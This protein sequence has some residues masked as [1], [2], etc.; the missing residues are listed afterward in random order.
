MFN[1]KNKSNHQ[2]SELP[3]SERPEW[4]ILEKVALSSL[5]EQKKARRWGIFFKGLTF[6]YLFALLSIMIPGGK[7][8]G[9]GGIHKVK[10]V[11]LVSLQ[12][13]I[14][15]ESQA[16]ANA[17]VRGLRA[18]FEAENSVGVILSINSP[19]GSPVQS[20]YINDEIFRLRDLHPE[21]KIYAVISDIG[22]S[23]G[24]YVASAAHEIYADK[25]SLVGSIGVISGGFGFT[26]LMDKVGVERRVYSSGNN[27][28]FLD[29]FSP[30]KEGEREFWQGVLG[31]T[32]Q[33]FIDVVKKGRGERLLDDPEIFSGLIWTGEQ[34]VDNGL[35]DSLGSVGYVA[36]DVIGTDEIRDYSVQPLPW[37]AFA[38]RLGASFSAGVSAFFS[39]RLF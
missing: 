30:E 15:S 17:V 23:G 14:A 11:G 34:A 24:Y 38:K 31:V 7:Q 27:K 3:D 12:G 20:G 10:H 21:K 22:A 33:Q 36:R 1:L 37:E 29:M 18:A 2:S 32:H 13:V 26:G 9:V 35:I 16:N 39:N 25:A 5:A 19:G 4:K 6:V 28:A 8:A